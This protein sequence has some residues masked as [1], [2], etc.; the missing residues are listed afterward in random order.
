MPNCREAIDLIKNG[1]EKAIAEAM[2][3]LYEDEELKKIAGYYHRRYPQLG[4]V[5]DW[6]DLL[7]EVIIRL[8]AE[9]QAGRGPK[10]NCLAYLRSVCRNICEEHRRENNRLAEAVKL[11]ATMYRIPENQV[12]REKVETWLEKLAGQCRMLLW[13]Y[14]FEEPPVTDHPQLAEI[15]NGAGFNV[16]PGSISTLLSRCRKGFRDLLNGDT[17]VFFDE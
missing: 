13:L 14:Y 1:E 17:S 4:R 7:T 6:E 3:R 8:I 12:L 15:L 9:I 2:K 16:G 10:S 11:L 5:L